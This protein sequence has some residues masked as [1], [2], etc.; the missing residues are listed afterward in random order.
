MLP[1]GFNGGRGNAN[2]DAELAVEDSLPNGET[3]L[4]RAAARGDMAEA[5]RHLDERGGGTP[6]AGLR[7]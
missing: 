7:L 5:R 2:A 4:M 3:A 6:V 1:N